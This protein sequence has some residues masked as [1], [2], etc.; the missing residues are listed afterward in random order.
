MKAEVE[1]HMDDEIDALFSLTL[2]MQDTIPITIIDCF[3]L[4]ICYVRWCAG[5]YWGNA[6]E[7]KFIIHVFWS[8]TSCILDR[9]KLRDDGK[10]A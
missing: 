10:S 4:K 3:F 6:V 7:A 1:K 8:Y 9:L 5:L 2:W